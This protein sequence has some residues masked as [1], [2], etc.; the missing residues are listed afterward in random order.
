[1]AES[2]L[3]DELSARL[4]KQDEKVPTTIRL[5]RRLLKRLRDQE[6][7]WSTSM[8]FI[9]EKALEPIL[10]ELEQAKPPSE[11]DDDAGE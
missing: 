1:M 11:D 2:K 10:A 6:R 7:R 5:S 4:L 3:V 9:V 8:S